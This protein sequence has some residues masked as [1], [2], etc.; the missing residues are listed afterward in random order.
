MKVCL[1]SFDIWGYD[2]KIVSKLNDL[3]HQAIHIKLSDYKYK[4]KSK[5][6]RV[7]NFLSKTFLKKNIKRINAEKHIIEIL[8]KE[9]NFDQI[10][11]INPEWISE[12][13]HHKIKSFTTNYTAYLYDSLANY[14]A[15]HLLSIFNKVFS[16]DKHDVEKYNLI[17]LSNFMHVEKNE[18]PV[19]S[20]YKVFSIASVDER[21]YIFKKII[22][23]LNDKEISHL[24]IFF[25]KK[26]PK[27]E[28]KNTIFTDK[29]ISQEEVKQ[30]IEQSEI[31]L[32]VLKNKQSGLSFRIFEAIALDKKIITTNQS[33]STYDFYNPNNIFLI[34]DE[35]INI[36]DSF[37]NNPYQEIPTEIWKK[38]TLESWINT[39]LN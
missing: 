24:S 39:I 38:Y 34:N 35:D 32:D 23:F 29:R 3:G 17:F 13:T 30:K 12:Q 7:Q 20:K 8:E 4:Y 2:Q 31:I 10:I 14:D 9:R 15:R 16:F 27:K 18:N 28:I 19:Q 37:F 36:P 5:F 11:V 22:N 6:E 26:K 25:D 33:I 21:Y 1:I